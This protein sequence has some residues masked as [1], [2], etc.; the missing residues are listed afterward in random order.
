MPISSEEFEQIIPKFEKYINRY[1][2]PDCDIQAIY[3]CIERC[4]TKGYDQPQLT[5]RLD[6]FIAQ[7]DAKK[8]AKKLFSVAEA[9][10]N[11]RRKRDRSSKA[12]GS[13]S[14]YE[15]I[16][17]KR[18]SSLANSIHPQTAKRVLTDNENTI[19][20]KSPQLEDDVFNNISVE[21]PSSTQIEN[22]M[23][24]AQKQIQE[25]QALLNIDANDLK[26][27]QLVDLQSRI[28]MQMGSLANVL[29]VS[30]ERE[31]PVYVTID[32]DGRTI[33]TRTGQIL[34][35]ESR[36]P[37]LKANIRAQ[38]HDISRGTASVLP[39]EN[40]TTFMQLSP[41]KKKSLSPPSLPAT[42]QFYSQHVDSRVIMKPVVKQKRKGFNFVNKGKY[43]ELAKKMRAKERLELLQK[44]IEEN[45]K[46]TKIVAESKYVLI[47]QSRKSL[48][49]VIPNIEWWDTVIIHDRNYDRLIGNP[50]QD[51]K[52]LFGISNLVEHP[53]QIKPQA[54]HNPMDNALP[55]YLTKH[56]RKKLRRQN[57]AEALREQQEKIRLGLIQPPEPKVRMSN[58][59]RVLG[60]EAVQDPS[61]VE[62]YVKNQMEKRFRAHQEANESRK[63][64][65][66]QKHEKVRQ[67]LLCDGVNQGLLSCV[68]RVLDL[69]DPAV[70]FK[71]EANCKQLYM[72]GCV[73]LCKEVN[74]VVVEGGPKQQKKYKKLMLRRIKWKDMICEKDSMEQQNKCSLVWEGLIKDRSFPEIQFKVSPSETFAREY[75]RKHDVEHYW[76]I[77]LSD[78]ILESSTC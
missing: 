42:T 37:T 36:L 38:R 17:T 76:N 51:K 34:H 68:Y 47:H 3:A 30:E 39:S 53:M 29:G 41:V 27:K 45:V 63:L 69:S 65:S 58:L 5:D 57:R 25:R 55:V 18:S 60:S 6:K 23:M 1:T 54:S 2:D 77:V 19:D 62:T 46:K 21:F 11:K 24:S 13:D 44:D 59:M 7:R 35:M 16:P 20:R 64:T 32:R 9:Y 12:S 73:V 40:R 28:S 71:I 4:F 72:T 70:K 10:H 15:E 26:A 56:E 61:K 52:R 74:V 33:D 43:E 22:V 78:V 31:R 14:D 8:L 66:D 49:E 75:F 50:E 67:K 48:Q